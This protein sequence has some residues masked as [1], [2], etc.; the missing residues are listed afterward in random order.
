MVKNYILVVV[1]VQK[2]FLPG[3]ALGVSEGNEVISPILRL[4]DAASIIIA[5]QDWHPSDHCSF[6]EYGGSWPAHCV[7]GTPGAA[8]HPA[9]DYI[10]DYIVR[11]GTDPDLEEYSAA[12][13][14]AEILEGHRMINNG[15]IVVTGLATDYCVKA[16]AI[17]L[18][19]TGYPVYVKLDAVRGVAEDTTDKAI[20]DMADAGVEVLP[21]FF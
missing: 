10:A 20:L 21:S 16:T 13:K 4:A 11:K 17:D 6:Q 8:L 14:I 15:S 19:T 3:G 18:V 5:S 2:D 1:D 12:T 9:I 7:K